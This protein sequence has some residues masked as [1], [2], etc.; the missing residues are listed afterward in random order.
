[1]STSS[2][3]VDVMSID[4]LY[5]HTSAGKVNRNS[6]EKYLIDNGCLEWCHDTSNYRGEHDQTTGTWTIEE[7]YQTP[8]VKHDLFEYIKQTTKVGKLS[9]LPSMAASLKKLINAN[10]QRAQQGNQ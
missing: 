3:Q 8:Y 10:E 9:S 6:F 4:D 5:I 7:Y 1:M 2:S